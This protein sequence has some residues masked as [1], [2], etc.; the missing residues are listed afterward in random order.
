MPA[1]RATARTSPFL[2]AFVRISGRAVGFEKCS[3]QVA[4]AVRVVLDLC[5]M[6]T[7][8]T[9]ELGFRWVS[10]GGLARDELEGFVAE[11]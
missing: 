11:L 10:V 9:W 3:V 8:W 4:I 6:G 7:M 5:A 2:S 1:I